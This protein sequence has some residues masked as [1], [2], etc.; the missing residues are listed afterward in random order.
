MPI[1]DPDKI[2][3]LGELKRVAFTQSIILPISSSTGGGGFNYL[4]A[5]DGVGLYAPLNAD[6]KTTMWVVF[7]FT[8]GEIWSCD[9]YIIDATG[10]SSPG[11]IHL[12][13]RD[14]ARSLKDYTSC[15]M[16]LGIPAPIKWEIG[17]EGIKGRG[18]FIPND[19][20]VRPRG[21]CVS[22]EIIVSGTFYPDDD[23]LVAIEPF[24]AK[25]YDMCGLTNQLT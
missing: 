20:F 14:L 4:R 16:K 11:S 2:W 13:R 22:N 23:P 10:E 19:P 8:N 5:E 7:V 24:F 6:R 15:L 17:L 9:S 12:D 18:I 21:A 25:V 1:N 3:S